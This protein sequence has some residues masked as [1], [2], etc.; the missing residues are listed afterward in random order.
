MIHRKRKKRLPGSLLPNGSKT[1]DTG[2][3]AK[4]EKLNTGM[5]YQA[6]ESIV[7]KSYSL[8]EEDTEH[9]FQFIAEQPGSTAAR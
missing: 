7:S 4:K 8:D 3:S 2:T 5:A 6:I 1:V 9:K